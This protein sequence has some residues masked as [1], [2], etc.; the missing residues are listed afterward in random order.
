MPT[1]LRR[2]ENRDGIVLV[3]PITL[4]VLAIIIVPILWTAV[5]SFQDVRYSSLARNGLAN[6][7]TLENY[8][9]VLTSRDFWRTLWV[10]VQYSV[11]TTAGSILVGL[12]AALA[13]RDRFRFR[14]PVRALMLLPYVAPVVATAFVWQVALNPQYGIVNA[15]GTRLLGWDNPVNFLG[16]APAALWTVIVYDVWRY[17]PFAFLFLAAALTGL[18]RE[19]EEAAVVD[20]ASSVQR[21]RHV[22]LPQLMPTIALLALL[23]LVMTF[24][25]FDDVYLLTGGAA[26]TEVAAV[27]VYDRLTGSSDIGGA[28]ADAVVLAILLGAAL[29][30]YLRVTN[31]RKEER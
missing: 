13:L 26:G 30:V 19:I 27:R 1:S 29:I 3:T 22:V 2:Q 17:F 20:G 8:T 23:L 31:R 11:A 16:S 21:F 7:F 28:S 6:P 24:N 5:L 25:K 14:A 12:G 18:P 4:I 10:T 9:D 15:V